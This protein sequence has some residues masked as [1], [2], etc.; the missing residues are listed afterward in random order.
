MNDKTIAGLLITAVSV[1]AGVIAYLFK[2]YI[3]QSK[4]K[5]A[6]DISM[7]KERESWA[8]ERLKLVGDHA[9]ERQRIMKEA[10]VQEAA[11]RADYEKRHRE[12]IERYDG[13]ARADSKRMLDHED[14][15]RKDFADIME[16]VSGEHTKA[17]ESLVAML[18]KFYE[19]FVG[20]R[21]HY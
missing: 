4:E 1:L 14:E 16:R 15:V 13:I 21:T 7:A 20:P 12:V 9:L 6:T 19:R 5:N 10:E 17:N 8:Q 18:H 3:A 2:L 11:L